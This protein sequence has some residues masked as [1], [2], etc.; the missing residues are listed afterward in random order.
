M[1][2]DGPSVQIASPRWRRSVSARLGGVLGGRGWRVAAALAVAVGSARAWGR[3]WRGCTN[4]DRWFGR[5]LDDDVDRC[6]ERDAVHLE[7]VLGQHP[8]APVG[9]LAP[10]GADD[11]FGGEG[12]VEGNDGVAHSFPALDVFGVSVEVDHDRAVAGRARLLDH[13]HEV[14]PC[15]R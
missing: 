12:S 9:N 6:A 1:F 4:G 10:A 2:D 14:A 11:L 15:R 7:L 3:A 5:A 8:E 13:S